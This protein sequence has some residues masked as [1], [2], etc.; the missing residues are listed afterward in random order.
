MKYTHCRILIGLSLCLTH[1]IAIAD[2][3]DTPFSKA[4]GAELFVSNDNENFSTQRLALEYL[5]RYHSADALTG[6]RYTSHWY[7]QNNWSLNGQQLTFLQRYI[8][9]ATANGWQL[10]AGLFQQGGHDLLTLDGNYRK[11]LAEHTGLELFVNRDWVET[12]A[13]LD[14]GVHFTLAGVAL[15]QGLGTHVTLVGLGA[16]QN[17][18]DGNARNHGRL[19]LILQPNLDSGLTLQARYRAYDSTSDNVGGVYFNPGHYTETML[20]L[21]WRKKI[22]GWNLNLTTGIGQQKIAD[23][24]N[25]TTHLL[26]GGLQSPPNRHYSLRLRAGLVKSASFNSAHYRYHY[27]Q[28]EWIIPF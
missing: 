26:E 19:K 23:D 28:T 27:L 4:A 17:F 6:V 20:A 1:T 21:G 16:R 7:Q 2:P 10:N 15:D 24:P 18:S 3:M 12:A 25:S 9:P 22:Q 8:D 13:A 5:P 14:N 11:A